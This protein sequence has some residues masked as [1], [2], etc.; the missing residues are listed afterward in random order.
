MSLPISSIRQVATKIGHPSPYIA[1]EPTFRKWVRLANEAQLL[2][3]HPH[4]GRMTTKPEVIQEWINKH[5]HPLPVV[6]R[7]R[8]H[9]RFK[10]KVNPLADTVDII[11]NY[12]RNSHE[13]PFVLPEDISREERKNYPIQLLEEKLEREFKNEIRDRILPRLRH[14]D[15]ANAKVRF[16]MQTTMK[17]CEGEPRNREIHTGQ[18]E[19]NLSIASERNQIFETIKQEWVNVQNKFFIHATG[20]RAPE[21]WFRAIQPNILNPEIEMN[22]DDFVS[23]YSSDYWFLYSIN[24]FELEIQFT[25]REKFESQSTNINRSY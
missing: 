3:W 24:Y 22:Q 13:E 6:P 16:I 20:N 25:Y 7:L 5:R 11:S 15:N 8:G 9:C 21:Q 12:V 23:G 14:T 19:I 1:R 18:I 2:G 10:T 4:N 17:N